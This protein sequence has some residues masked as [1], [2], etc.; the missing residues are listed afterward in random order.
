VSCRGQSLE[1]RR[2]AQ[3]DAASARSPHA[4]RDL[5]GS[6]PVHLSGGTSGPAVPPNRP[7]HSG[8]PSRRRTHPWRDERR[9]SRT[10]PQPT[11]TSPA[12]D[13]RSTAGGPVPSQR[14]DT[15]PPRGRAARPTWWPLPD[16]A[17]RPDP[18]E[19]QARLPQ[20]PI[21][22][23]SPSPS[24]RSSTSQPPTSSPDADHARRSI[25]SPHALSGP[26]ATAPPV[27][28][29]SAPVRSAS[30]PVQSAQRTAT[31]TQ[32]PPTA[33]RSAVLPPTHSALICV[34]LPGLA[35][36]TDQGQLTGRGLDGFYRAGR[37]VLSRCQ[38]RVAGR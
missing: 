23:T 36:S 16:Q 6:L 29:A 32:L 34:A 26:Q 28:C 1:G 20:Q 13:D 24:P 12:A 25:P 2:R 19:Q 37:R 5:E 21:R 31:Q 11:P 27:Q 30:A 33:R 22:P 10:M 17:G 38:I 7:C 8:S 14:Q 4:A 9:G 3:R 35:I 15:G 18:Q